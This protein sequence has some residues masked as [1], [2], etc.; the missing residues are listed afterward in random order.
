MHVE[1]FVYQSYELVVRSVVNVILAVFA[2]EHHKKRSV[3]RL[4]ERNSD[5]SARIVDKRVLENEAGVLDSIENHL[6]K[7]Y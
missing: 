6:V 1:V 5:L 3:E 4:G 7:N 2:V